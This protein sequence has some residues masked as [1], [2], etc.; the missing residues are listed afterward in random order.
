MNKIAIFLI[1]L[2]FL[3]VSVQGQAVG[4]QVLPTDAP[5]Y[6]LVIDV[7]SFGATVNRVTD[8]YA[9]IQAAIN[10]AELVN[11]VVFIPY[12]T[13]IIK[14]GLTIESGITVIGTSR[15]GSVIKKS[16][17]IVGITVDTGRDVA[18]DLG[19]HVVLK[20]F[21]LDS[22]GG[23]DAK[24][25]IRIVD[26]ADGI[27]DDI[28]VINQGDDGIEFQ[29]GNNSSFSNLYLSFNDGDGILI[30][31]SDI[32]TN[33]CVFSNIDAIQNG[34][35]GFNLKEGH[36]NWCVGICT[37]YNTG[38]G[39]YLGDAYANML[40]IYSEANTGEQVQLSANAKA[41]WLHV[42]IPATVT[43]NGSGN[44]IWARGASDII[45]MNRLT[46]IGSTYINNSYIG[47]GSKIYDNA[48]TG[49]NI[50]FGTG[51]PEGAVVAP[52]G[53]LFL[54]TDGGANTTLYIKEANTTNLGWVAK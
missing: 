33:A 37:Q 13:F 24:D 31:A 52:V 22:A 6:P 26:F 49:A 32:N 12:G 39:V 43:D 36:E 47:T 34:A 40:F 3:P 20:R 50:R 14:T 53:S 41:N 42:G 2:F 10:A 8:D 27:V 7:R 16:G 19:G 51:T 35:I 4:I 11:G 46:V 44:L 45:K 54:R 15:K 29:K 18:P 25:G 1:F 21:T 5:T 48:V 30:D 28:T 38:D 9:A 17:N 23:V